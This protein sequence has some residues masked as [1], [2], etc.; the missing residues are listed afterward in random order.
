MAMTTPNII[1]MIKNPVI[2]VSDSNGDD[3]V[4]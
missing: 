1:A 3:E 2:M 4:D